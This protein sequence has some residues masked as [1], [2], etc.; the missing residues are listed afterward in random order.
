MLQ[1]TRASMHSSMHIDFLVSA[2]MIEIPHQGCN[3]TLYIKT[4]PRCLE[5]C[6]KFRRHVPPA[7]KL[8]ASVSYGSDHRTDKQLLPLPAIR[9]HEP[10]WQLWMFRG[11]LEE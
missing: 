6:D 9:R 5:N 2:K 11:K 1:T 7:R 3:Q 10:M 8:H 4:I